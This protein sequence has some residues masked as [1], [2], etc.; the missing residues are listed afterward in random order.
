MSTAW[1]GTFDQLGP[2]E[3][4]DVLMV[5]RMF[6]P[7]AEVVL[8]AVA[9]APGEGVLDVATGP[10]TVARLAAGRVGADGHVTGVDISDAMLTVAR[11]KP[12]VPDGAPVT[13]VESSACPLVG[14]EDDSFDVVTCQQ[15]LQFFPDRPGAL[16]EMARALVPGGRIGVACWASQDQ[17]SLF[18]A[19][20]EALAEVLGPEAAERYRSGPWG[21][22][23]P[24]LLATLLRGAGFEDVE[25]RPHSLDVTWDTME[26]VVTL[27]DVA[28]VA[29]DVAALS[30][31]GKRA[32]DAAVERRVR[33]FGDEGGILCPM[34]TLLGLGRATA[35]P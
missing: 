9:V 2:M 35:A 32:L 34:V 27:L 16:A 15:G 29:D 33:P 8:D 24:D 23:D 28:A 22:S 14:I 7:L 30:D 12:P 11:R 20:T 17:S 1:G 18:A 26:E 4:Y 31:E 13:W 5:P 25:V 3:V 19:L 6:Q 10:G 21:L